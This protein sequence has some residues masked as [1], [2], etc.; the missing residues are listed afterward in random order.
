[1]GDLEDGAREAG[2]PGILFGIISEQ[3]H[4]NRCRIKARHMSLNVCGLDRTRKFYCQSETTADGILG[5]RM[6]FAKVYR[7]DT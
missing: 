1:M 6:E 5:D 7:Y 3:W 4:Y 2:F